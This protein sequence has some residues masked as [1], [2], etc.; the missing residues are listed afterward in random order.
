MKFTQVNQEQIEQ[1]NEAID[2]IIK[3]KKMLAG[4]RL[5]NKIFGK[6]TFG[7]NYTPINITI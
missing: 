5:V 2:T 1:A 6:D 4:Q 3:L 7:E